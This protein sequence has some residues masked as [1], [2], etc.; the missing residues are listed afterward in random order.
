MR[1]DDVGHSG[2]TDHERRDQKNCRKLTHN[3]IDDGNSKMPMALQTQRDGRV[4][5]RITNEE[6]RRTAGNSPTMES[7]MEIRRC[8]WLSKLSAMEES[9]SPMIRYKKYGGP[10]HPRRMLGAWSST[11]RAVGRPQQ[12]HAYITTLEKLGFEGE[13]G[14]LRE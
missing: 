11:P 13:K 5:R 2:E 12:S 14:Q 9:R 1:V 8:R 6:T 3:G 4:K 10:Y 7:M